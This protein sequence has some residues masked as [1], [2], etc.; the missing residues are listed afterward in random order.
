MRPKYKIIGSKETGN[1]FVCELLENEE[2]TIY[3]VKENKV[4]GIKECRNW[5]GKRLVGFFELKGNEIIE[6]Q[7]I[8]PG[9]DE[10][11]NPTHKWI[12]DDY[13]L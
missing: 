13:N 10:N 7:C 4:S 11:K 9:R 6:H 3:E 2:E 5:I 8:K 1:Y 12:V